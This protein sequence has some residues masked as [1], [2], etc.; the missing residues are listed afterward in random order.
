MSISKLFLITLRAAG[1][2]HGLTLLFRYGIWE[3]SFAFPSAL[4]TSP[5]HVKLLLILCVSLRRSPVA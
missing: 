5:R 1:A 4:M 3:P 2:Q